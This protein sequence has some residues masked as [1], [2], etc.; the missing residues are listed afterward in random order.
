LKAFLNN[1]GSFE[2]EKCHIVGGFEGFASVFTL[3]E[4]NLRNDLSKSLNVFRKYAQN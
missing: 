4:N 2:D 3:G 1:V